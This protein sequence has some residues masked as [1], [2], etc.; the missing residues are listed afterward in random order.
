MRVWAR[1]SRRS[2]PAKLGEF[3]QSSSAG[4]GPLKG[5]P[6]AGSSRAQAC[7][8]GPSSPGPCQASA[9]YP[10]RPSRA[11]CPVA[12]RSLSTLALG[13]PSTGALVERGCARRVPGSGL[14][15]VE[16]VRRRAPQEDALSPRRSCSSALTPMTRLLSTWTPTDAGRGSRERPSLTLGPAR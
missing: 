8:P 6:T 10:R 5:P 4:G 12:G 2:A 15:R 14:A 11:A 3:R 16:S 13:S 1:S 9:L 7:A